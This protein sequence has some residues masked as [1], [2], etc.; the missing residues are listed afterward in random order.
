MFLY[1]LKGKSWIV[2]FN[3]NSSVESEANWLFN[4]HKSLNY[5]CLKIYQNFLELETVFGI[6]A[7]WK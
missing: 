5:I 3:E 2:F 6:F 7:V 4:F 1:R